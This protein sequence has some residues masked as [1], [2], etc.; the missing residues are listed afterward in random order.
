MLD[1]L[2]LRAP[3]PFREKIQ[4]LI[5][6]RV[7]V[8]L[9]QLNWILEPPARLPKRAPCPKRQ[10]SIPDLSAIEKSQPQPRAQ[11]QDI[12]IE[13]VTMMIM[14]MLKVVET[15]LPMEV[16]IARIRRYISQILIPRTP[17]RALK[18]L[19]MLATIILTLLRS[20]PNLK[21]R[22]GWTI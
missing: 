4:E 19:L 1:H 9:P 6:D 7:L 3:Q 13:V 17:N 8:T 2:N 18:I 16:I 22:K 12:I 11:T 15:T 10:Q 5:Q 20:M 21:E 14:M